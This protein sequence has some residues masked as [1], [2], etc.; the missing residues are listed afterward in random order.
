MAMTKI[1][2]STSRSDPGVWYIEYYFEDNRG[3]TFAW[4]FWNTSKKYKFYVEQW[5]RG[6]CLFDGED[7]FWE[8]NIEERNW[9]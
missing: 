3:N 9:G 4:A 2:R 7:E 5:P 1:V 6:I 8:V